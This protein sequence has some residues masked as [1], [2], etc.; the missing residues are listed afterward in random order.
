MTTAIRY[1]HA[2]GFVAG[3]RPKIVTSRFEHADSFTLERFLATG[4]YVG[5]RKALGRAATDVHEEVKNAT[6]LGRGGA[7]FPAGTKWGLTP[8]QVFPKY[9]VVNGDESEPGTYKD[10]LLMERDPHQLIEGC[11]IAC[12]AAG[13]SQCFLYIRGEMALAQ[14]RV[15]AALNEAYAAGYVG[16]NILGSKFSVDIVL[17]WG[18]GA[19]VVGE[20][21]ALIESLEGNRGMPRLKPPF[22]PAANGLYGQPTIVNNVETLA[23]LPWLMVNGSEAYTA[24]GTKTS[25]G[26]RMVAVSGH[27]KNPGVFEIINGTTT[28]RDLLYGA[29]FCGGIRNDNELKA[30]VPGGGSAPWFTADQLDLPFEASQVGPAGSM[31]GS[32]AI[33]VMDSTT[34][35]PAAALTLT[36]FY[37][38]ESCGKCTPCRE[39]GTWLERILTRIVNGTGT[40]ADLQ[41]I[42]EVGAM[43]CPGDFPHASNEKLGLDAVPFPYKMTTICFVGPSAFAPLH[44]AITL[45]RSEFESRLV[46]R[47]SIPVTAVSTQSA[48]SA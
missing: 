39:G 17:H 37:A 4:G 33:M 19:Y 24:I 27:V 41:Q 26:T 7:G 11:L 1:P 40:E 13:L 31:L 21:T 38:H 32:G 16:K 6:V 44:S 3:D 30:F 34:D 36:H 45:F 47:I 29:E 22:F 18:A 46:R 43:I 10:R 12:Y 23:N 5:L 9:L 2:T 25:P 15:A 35:I 8:Q 42:F 14:E 20:E 28:F 48:V